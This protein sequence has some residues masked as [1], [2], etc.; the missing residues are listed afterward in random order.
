MKE[1]QTVSGVVPKGRL[2]IAQHAVLG[3]FALACR[4]ARK[5]AW[6]TAR[7]CAQATIEN[8]PIVLLT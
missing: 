2:K 3:L 7:K 5:R 8:S 4:T 1:T 6:Q